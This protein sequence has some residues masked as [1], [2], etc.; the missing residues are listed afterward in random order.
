MLLSFAAARTDSHLSRTLRTLRPARRN[1]A[2]TGTKMTT[3]GA[4]RT[5]PNANIVCVWSVCACACT[6]TGIPSPLA[7]ISV[8]SVDIQ[9]S[10]K[11]I[12]KCAAASQAG[13]RDA[14]LVDVSLCRIDSFFF[15][16]LTLRHLQHC[17]FK[18]EILAEPR[19]ASSVS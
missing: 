1:L 12:M 7:V 4:L 9:S 18:W 6:T 11:V 19:A 2:V 8:L 10:C 17:L 3:D 15:A 5:K 13:C 16:P 14:Y